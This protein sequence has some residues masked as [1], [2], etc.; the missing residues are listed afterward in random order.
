M[1]AW[2]TDHT[3]ARATASGAGALPASWSSRLAAAGQLAVHAAGLGILMW[4]RPPPN[5]AAYA[6][7]AQLLVTGTWLSAV[8]LL[9]GPYWT[10]A[11]R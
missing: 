7:G 2:T 4:F 1:D 10:R 5:E 9:I 6:L 3:R 8:H 11:R